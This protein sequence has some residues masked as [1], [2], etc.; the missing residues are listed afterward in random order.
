METCP[1]SY[2]I[3]VIEWIMSCHKHRMTTRV[4]KLWR[5]DETSLT[6]SVLTKRVFFLNIV[7][8]QGDKFQF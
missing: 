5:I 3:A 7:H 8:F 2:D 1:L 4:I 6:L